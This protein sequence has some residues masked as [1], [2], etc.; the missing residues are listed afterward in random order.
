MDVQKKHVNKCTKVSVC[1]LTCTFNIGLW[2]GSPLLIIKN[3]VFHKLC[4]LFIKQRNTILSR[5][6]FPFVL[7]VNLNTSGK[8]HTF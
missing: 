7:H 1:L 4:N 2:L 6:V 8:Y 5:Y 3:A